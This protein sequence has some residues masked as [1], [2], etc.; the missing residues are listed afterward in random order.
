MTGMSS[1]QGRS[2]PGGGIWGYRTGEA[3]EGGRRTCRDELGMASGE[4][5]LGRGWNGTC[6]YDFGG[7]SELI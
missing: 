5:D 4:G 6:I 3:G 2:L 7:Q 1:P